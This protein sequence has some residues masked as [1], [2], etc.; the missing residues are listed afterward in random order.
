MCVFVCVCVCVS[1]HVTRYSLVKTP[2]N[3]ILH[4]VN[5]RSR[6]NH[7]RKYFNLRNSFLTF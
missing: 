4:K 3:F 6:T 2:Y 7:S 1:Q 5:N